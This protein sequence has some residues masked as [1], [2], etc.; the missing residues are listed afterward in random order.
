MNAVLRLAAQWDPR[1]GKDIEEVKV[2]VSQG[3][4]ALTLGASQSMSDFDGNTSGAR[5]SWMPA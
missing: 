5:S 1:R 2:R 4:N 3:D